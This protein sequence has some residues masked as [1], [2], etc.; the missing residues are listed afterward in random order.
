MKKEKK[1]SKK[2][3]LFSQ[4]SVASDKEA[5]RKFYFEEYLPTADDEEGLGPSDISKLGDL[6]SVLEKL[7]RR[8]S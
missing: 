6:A 1:P 2:P 7:K 3:R 5:L 8:P 4:P